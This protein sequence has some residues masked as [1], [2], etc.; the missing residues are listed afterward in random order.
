MGAQDET[1][2]YTIT[3]H[4]HACTHNSSHNNLGLGKLENTL[5]L[6]LGLSFAFHNFSQLSRFQVSSPRGIG[7]S[8]VGNHVPNYSI[9]HADS[10]SM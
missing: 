2:A 7:L 5:N 4:G 10:K 1:C 3:P 9:C 8:V 6:K